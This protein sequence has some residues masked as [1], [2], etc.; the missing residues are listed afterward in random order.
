MT[1]PTRPT[2]PV[3]ALQVARAI[4]QASA[5]AGHARSDTPQ[6]IET[7][8]RNL[9]CCGYVLQGDP[10]D[11][12]QRPGAIKV[13]IFSEPKGGEDDCTPPWRAG[14][15]DEIEVM[16]QASSRLSKYVIESINPAVAGVYGQ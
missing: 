3:T 6:D 7:R 8:A 9:V 16:C 13:T 1:R 14:D 5:R 2:H 12:G 4:C 10:Y 11:W 15:L